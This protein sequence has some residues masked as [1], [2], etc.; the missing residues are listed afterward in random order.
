MWQPQL[1]Q[2]TLK[3]TCASLGF[4]LAANQRR[5]G[6]QVRG[7]GVDANERRRSFPGPAGAACPR[8]T[9]IHSDGGAKFHNP[10]SI[11]IDSIAALH[12]PEFVAHHWHRLRSR[13]VPPPCTAQPPWSESMPGVCVFR[14]VCCIFSP[15][16]VADLCLSGDRRHE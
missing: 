13:N 7:G 8:S 12:T 5:G 1:S 14:S 4:S 9:D 16:N 2:P 15:L 3:H 10:F 11:I 6:R